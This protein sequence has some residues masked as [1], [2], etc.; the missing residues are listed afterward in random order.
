MTE[1]NAGVG[2]RE[3][4]PCWDPDAREERNQ[5]Q[6][7]KLTPSAEARPALTGP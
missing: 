3:P 2:K 6:W 1:R 7:V 5:C 4:R